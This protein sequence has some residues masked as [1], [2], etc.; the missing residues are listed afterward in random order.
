M[1]KIDKNFTAAVITLSDKGS[2]GERE[3]ITG[4]E[5]SNFIKENL[6]ISFIKYE[7]IP[8][9]KDVLENLLIELA[10]NQKI[11]II[12]TNGSTGIAPRDIA[13]DV[14]MKVVQKRLP[15]FE[16]AMRMES[17]KITP[18]ALISRAVCG[19]RND[20]FII[21]LPG[22]PK[23]AIENLQVVIKAIPHLVK[24]LQGDKTDCAVN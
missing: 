16:E 4:I 12:I 2:R 10:D 3:D 17:F 15:G 23:G 7:M 21:N 1:G 22:S 8:D 11:D 24:K 5:V 14:T 18:H 20:S 6:P 9:E 19:T 13:P